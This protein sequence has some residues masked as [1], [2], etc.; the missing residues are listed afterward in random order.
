MAARFHVDVE[1]VSWEM[2]DELTHKPIVVVR[3]NRLNVNM[4]ETDILNRSNVLE[5]NT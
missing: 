5:S 1:G 4:V 3:K 2:L